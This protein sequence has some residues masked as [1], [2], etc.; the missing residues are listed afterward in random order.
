MLFIITSIPND[1]AI[2]NGEKAENLKANFLSSKQFDMPSEIEHYFDTIFFS[3][4]FYLQ[5]WVSVVTLEVNFT[6]LLTS[7]ACFTVSKSK[8]QIQETGKTVAK[9]P[10]AIR[11]SVMQWNDEKHSGVQCVKRIPA[12]SSSQLNQPLSS[13]KN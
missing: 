10:G 1:E 13:S 11:S 9:G 2:L 7:S 12:L 5:V 8:S 3:L 4:F 6:F